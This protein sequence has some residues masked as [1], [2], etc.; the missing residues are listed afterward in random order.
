LPTTPLSLPA[1]DPSEGPGGADISGSSWM[2]AWPDKAL[3]TKR[4]GCGLEAVEW[5]FETEV[6]FNQL[7]VYLCLLWLRAVS[8]NVNVC[9]C[10]GSFLSLTISHA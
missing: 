5:R 2:E 1:P 10:G 8:Q 4:S 9:V 3:T 7:I 6:D